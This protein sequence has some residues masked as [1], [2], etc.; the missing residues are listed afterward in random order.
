VQA[1]IAISTDGSS[2]YFVARG[3]LTEAPDPGGRQAVPGGENLYVYHAASEG[4]PGGVSFVATLPGSDSRHWGE[5]G[6]IGSANVTPDGRYL[7]FTSH[8]GLTPDVTSHEGPEQVYRYDARIKT[9]TRV[10]VGQQG[11]NNNGTSAKADARIAIAANGFE[12]D[13]PD[14]SNPTMSDSG[15]LVFFETPTGL[16][17]G[18]LDNHPVTGNKNV[19]AENIYEWEAQGARPSADAPACDQPAGCVRLI[20]DGHDLTEGSDAHLN[21]SAVELL[22][23]DSTGRNVFF[24]TSDQM[25]GWDTDSQVDLYD[26]R[27]DGGFAE[28]VPEPSCESLAECHEPAPPP[29][30]FG[31]LPTGVFSGLGN[32][33]GSEPPPGPPKSSVPTVAQQLA[34]ALKAC[35][36]ERFHHARQLCERRARARYRAQLLVAA[37]RA[38]RRRPAHERASCER[39]ARARYQRRGSTNKRSRSQE[40]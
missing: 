33:S 13:G 4:S 28:P 5:T 12:S 11:F 19:L 21:E 34:K 25:V 27:A 32:A 22:S 26:A 39:H 9:L 40:R 23:T 8:R 24:W 37:L 30:V 2:V 35:R 7:V 10:S 17:P 15:Q 29:P 38:C 16:T 1:V 31:A 14:R 18:A 6:G 20:S 3:V 36:S